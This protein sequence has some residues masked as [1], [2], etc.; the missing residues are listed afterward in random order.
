MCSNCARSRRFVA[1]SKLEEVSSP[2]T[3]TW[4]ARSGTDLRRSPFLNSDRS[5]GSSCFYSLASTRVWVVDWC[6]SG[7]SSTLY[8]WSNLM[9]RVTPLHSSR[10][11]RC[12]LR[13]SCPTPLRIILQL[14][15]CHAQLERSASTLFMN[16]RRAGCSAGELST[17][18]AHSLLD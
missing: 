10:S 6:L 15:D 4:T 1:C 7:R 16:S 17:F 2:A 5:S 14:R 13:L 11:R 12:N 18:F 8:R 3:T 9:K